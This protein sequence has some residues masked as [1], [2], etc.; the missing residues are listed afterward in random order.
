MKTLSIFL[1]LFLVYSCEPKEKSEIICIQPYGE[2]SSEILDSMSNGLTEVYQA[3]VYILMSKDLPQTAFVNIKTPRYRADSLLKDLLIDL[4]DSVSQ[5]IG[6]T[7]NDIS[8]TSRDEHGNIEEP[9]WKYTDWGVFGLGYQPGRSC[10]V[11]SFRLKNKSKKLMLER[12]R[13]VA[14]HEIGHNKGLRH[15]PT[16]YCVMQDAVESIK[17]VD[18]AKFQL[19]SACENSLGL[20]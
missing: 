8:T 5:I 17:T 6:I 10:V 9:K 15:C 19:C 12:I 11:S 18:S 2:V 3:K 13:K 20:N 14:I 16:K 4:P 7:T 1:A